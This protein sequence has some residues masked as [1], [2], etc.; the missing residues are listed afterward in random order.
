[1]EYTSDVD[2][3]P[4]LLTFYDNKPNHKG[5]EDTQRWIDCKEILIDYQ[6]CN[7]HEDKIDFNKLAFVHLREER[8]RIVKES[9]VQQKLK[10]ILKP[11]VEN[12][13]FYFI[14]INYPKELTELEKLK[15]ITSNISQLQWIDTIE[16]V[17]EYHTK[18]GGHPHC[19]MLIVAREK[20]PPSKVIDKI[21]AVKGLKKLIAGKQCVDLAKNRD[22]TLQNYRDYIN[23][24]KTESKTE[25]C[26]LDREWRIKNNLEY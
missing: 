13:P 23:G 21:F 19:H 2:Y 4:L 10:E 5:D 9:S 8:S 6:R 14:T 1:M 15:E 26:E 3:E 7:P 11:V 18:T 25:N 24:A 16:Y 12:S 22:K 17:Y 20:M